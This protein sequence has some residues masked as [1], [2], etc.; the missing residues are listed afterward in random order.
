M[1][2]PAEETKNL[3]WEPSIMFPDLTP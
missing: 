2:A 1:Y 3:L